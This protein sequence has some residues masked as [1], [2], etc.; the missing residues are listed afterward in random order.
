MQGSTLV[1]AGA[2]VLP[3]TPLGLSGDSGASSAPHLHLQAF[4]DGTNFDATNSI[5]ITFRNAGGMTK[6]SGELSE[7]QAYR[8]LPFAPG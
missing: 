4:R 6:A 5:P 3:G 1:A 2:A 7:G 8:A